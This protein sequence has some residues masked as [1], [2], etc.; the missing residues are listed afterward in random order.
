M[1]INISSISIMASVVCVREL[2][3]FKLGPIL[4]ECLRDFPEV[5]ALRKEQETCIIDLARDKDVFLILP[6][7]LSKNLIFQL[8][9]R[10]TKAAQG[11]SEEVEEDDKNVRLGNLEIVFGSPES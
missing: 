10:L 2:E 7:G 1:K 11:S 6:T 3:D 8:F 4:V 5:N 9:P